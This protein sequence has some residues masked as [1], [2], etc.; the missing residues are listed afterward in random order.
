M[1]QSIEFDI[2]SQLDE[3]ISSEIAVEILSRTMNEMRNEA[4]IQANQNSDTGELSSKI[5]LKVVSDEE[6]RLQSLAQHSSAMEYGTVPFWAPVQPLKDW[7]KRKLGDE[8]IGYAVQ[9]KI[10]KEGITAHPFFRP[11][12][13]ITMSVHLPIIIQEVNSKFN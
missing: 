7:A 9:K 8:N 2:K 11:A 10:A 13:D 1:V 4:I 3:N 12:Q 6:I 5:Q